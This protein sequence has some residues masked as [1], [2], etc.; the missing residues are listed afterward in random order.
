M[1]MWKFGCGYNNVCRS[2]RVCSKLCG[3]ALCG[4][5]DVCLFGCMDVRMCENLEMWMCDYVCEFVG[6]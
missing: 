3:C 5:V 2:F 6:A 1:G 4:C